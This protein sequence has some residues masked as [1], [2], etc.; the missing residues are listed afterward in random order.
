MQ[1]NSARRRESRRA[2][3][4]PTSKHADE[5][6]EFTLELPELNME[7]LEEELTSLHKEDFVFEW[8]VKALTNDVVC[9]P[10]FQDLFLFPAAVV[11]NITVKAY[12][13]C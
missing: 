13:T 4:S 10:I 9:I 3:K 6:I 12:K 7:M 5:S 2:K 11:L 8:D 1:K